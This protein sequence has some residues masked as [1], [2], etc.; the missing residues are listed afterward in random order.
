MDSSYDGKTAPEAKQLRFFGKMCL[1]NVLSEQVVP[2]HAPEY[3]TSEFFVPEYIM[4]EYPMP[5]Y[6]MPEDIISEYLM[7]VHAM[8]EYITSPPQ[9]IKP[10][11]LI[12]RWFR[13]PT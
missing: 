8:S 13:R 7:S 6:P 3:V 11:S 5:E 4:P 9:K 2:K 10:A 12:R 1:K